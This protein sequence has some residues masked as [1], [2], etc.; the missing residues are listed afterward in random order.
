MMASEAIL[1]N[2][3]DALRE[4]HRNMARLLNAL[5]HQIEVTALAGAPDYQLILGIAEYFCDYP[6]CCHHPKENAMLEQLCIKFPREAEPMGYL[7]WEHIDTHQRV[8]RFR[9][10]VDELIHEAIIPRAVVVN[11]ARG[12]VNAER[13]H[14]R[15][16]EER[17]FPVA[18]KCLAE[19]DWSCIDQRITKICGPLLLN[20]A[21]NEFKG[22][23]E[24]L[25]KWESSIG[26]A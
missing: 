8:I 26:H 14:M 18:E 9:R 13:R 3:I 6:D 4:E 25:L 24:R 15:I 7:T 21:E 10:I 16:E 19:E 1:A 5:E 23:S 17:F 12:F 22:I 2:V 11:V 20:H